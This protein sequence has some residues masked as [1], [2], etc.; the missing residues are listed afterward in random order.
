MSS[1]ALMGKQEKSFDKYTVEWSYHSDNGLDVG[2]F[3]KDID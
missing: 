3:V 2:F 1:N